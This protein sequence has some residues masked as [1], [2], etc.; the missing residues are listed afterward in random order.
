M[1]KWQK[2]VDGEETPIWKMY[3]QG[4]EYQSRIGLSAGIPKNVDFYE[5]RQWPQPT[6]STKNLPRPVIN[7]IKMICRSKRSAILSTPVKILYKSYSPRTDV[8]K[9]ND[10]LDN[11]LSEFNQDGLDKTAIDDGIKKG[12]YFF[13]YYWDNEAIGH[14]GRADGGVR[15]EIIDPLSI[16][17][18]NP[19]ETD[20]QK[21]DWILISST[22][23]K[24]KLLKICDPNLLPQLRTKLA[25]AEGQNKENS[26]KITLLTRYF[27]VN[28]EVF[29]ERGTKYAYVSAPFS[30]CPRIDGN[31]LYKINSKED[32]KAETEKNSSINSSLYNKSRAKAA[33]YP[34]VCGCYERREGSI[35]GISEVEGIIPN[36]KAINFNIA[37]SLLNA[38]QC[39]WG[40]YL[41]L[42]GALKGQKITNTP[43]Q[44]L[45]DHTGTGQGI[46]RMKEQELSSSPVAL[47]EQLTE[48]TRTASGVTEIMS[49]EALRSNMSG[50][51]IA[52]L[53][54]QAEVPIEELR[55]EF[56]EV[57][58]KQGMVLAQFI[59]LYYYDKE[60][61][62]KTKDENGCECEVCDYF[63][64]K[65]YESSI[66]EVVVEPTRGTRASIAS[67]INLLDNCLKNGKISLESY[68][69]AYPDGAIS[70]K[71]A[72]LKQI[73]EEK[74]SEIN[75]LRK[76]L[77]MYKNGKTVDPV[78]II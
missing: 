26:D 58:K 60:F 77:E 13:H 46:Q 6:E 9:L 70:N 59:R 3:S 15:C 73:E 28:G 53:Q 7:I 25:E 11:M 76:E 49:G 75:A 4:L 39:A 5:G 69:R 44:V 10:F 55:S 72:I 37:M 27:R 18:A 17:F 61:I 64:S 43:G 31:D 20:E 45:I 8:D 51:A 47:A 42:P 30:L 78:S 34:I 63:Y 67:D 56:W 71:T 38:Q 62:R 16:F 74:T 2:G 65:D 52:Q 24:E 35:F 40:K 32:D 54:A 41:A 21:Q 12:S 14:T 68:I 1:A 66:L 29:C 36:Q 48:L 22:V 50:V 57:K 19:R 23:T 33:L